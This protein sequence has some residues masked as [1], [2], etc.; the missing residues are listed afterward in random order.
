MGIAMSGVACGDVCF[1][2]TWARL[3]A[4]I[5]ST[6]GGDECVKAGQTSPPILIPFRYPTGT[7]HWL[8]IQPVSD[9]ILFSP[10]FNLCFLRL[11]HL[12]ILSRSAQHFHLSGFACRHLYKMEVTFFG[13]GILAELPERKG[14]SSHHQTCSL[15][16]PKSL[17]HA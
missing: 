1:F 15:L 13:R 14:Y 7:R 5:L 17:H 9:P 6:N 12:E 10:G 11:I 4:F 16:N 2:V 3:D 8:C